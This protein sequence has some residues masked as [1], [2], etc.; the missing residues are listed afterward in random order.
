MGFSPAAAAM[1]GAGDDVPV[2][3]YDTL[4]FSE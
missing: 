1:G 2:S 3:E 4:F